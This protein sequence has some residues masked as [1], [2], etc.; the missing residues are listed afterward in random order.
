MNAASRAASISVAIA[1]VLAAVWLVLAFD[2][3]GG[4]TYVTTPRHQHGAPVP[5]GTWRFCVPMSRT[6]SVTSSPIGATRSTR[7]SCTAS[8]P[9]TATGSCSRATT[10][11]GSTRTARRATNSAACSSAF[12]GGGAGRP[13]FARRHRCDGGRRGSCCWASRMRKPGRHT[14][15]FRA[16]T[17]GP[18]APPRFRCRPRPRPPGRPRLRSRALLAAVGCGVLLSM[19]M[20][21]TDVRSVTVTQQGQFSYSGTADPGTT[22]LTG[23]IA[24]GDTAGLGLRAG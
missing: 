8:S 11:T 12:P 13:P 2:A 23:V 24:T 21:A 10:T 4:T 18:P 5:P 9:W 7:S 1:L 6:P 20:T 15:W 17:R 3:G 22:Y 16:L 19:P 14:A